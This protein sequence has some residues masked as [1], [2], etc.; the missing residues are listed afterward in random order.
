[1]RRRSLDALLNQRPPLGTNDLVKL[2]IFSPCKH[3]HHA[4]GIIKVYIHACFHCHNRTVMLGPHI[5]SMCFQQLTSSKPI[6]CMLEWGWWWPGSEKQIEQG[7]GKYQSHI[8]GFATVASPALAHSLAKKPSANSENLGHSFQQI[9]AHDHDHDHH[10]HD[11]PLEACPPPYL[12]GRKF[13]HWQEERMRLSLQQKKQQQTMDLEFQKNEDHEH[14]FKTWGGVDPVV[15]SNSL[16]FSTQCIAQDTLSHVA[17]D[18]KQ[19]CRAPSHQL[20]PQ[21]IGQEVPQQVQREVPQGMTQHGAIPSILKEP[22]SDILL[23][24]SPQT[25][26]PSAHHLIQ[27]SSTLHTDDDVKAGALSPTLHTPHSTHRTPASTLH[28]DDDI[29]AGALSNP[30]P[31]IFNT[32]RQVITT[33]IDN[34]V[35]V[36][37]SPVPPRVS[38]QKP[39]S[40]S[41]CVKS[42]QASHSEA[43]VGVS[44]YDH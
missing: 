31:L 42:D 24:A 2:T 12:T 5:A 11:F 43:Q 35:H 22:P 14:G 33:M 15:S 34:L 21:C 16:Q 25:L 19:P 30:S 37:S 39:E 1:M 17:S 44:G 18:N 28:T 41:L 32:R 29:K 38:L 23:H 20:L 3:D 26:H 10:R 7:Q 40:Q 36:Q 9:P 27:C 6:G 8:Q 4:G 13:W